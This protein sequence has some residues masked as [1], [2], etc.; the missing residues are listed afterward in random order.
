MRFQSAIDKMQGELLSLDEPG[1]LRG[2][3]RDDIATGS[4][5]A[6]RILGR[7][8]DDLILG[9]P[10]FDDGGNDRLL[11]QNGDDILFGDAG[12][13]RL[14]GGKGRD[15]LSGEEGRDRL[16][17]GAGADQLFDGAG[18]DVMKGGGGRDQFHFSEVSGRGNV[19]RDFQN[20][21]DK[22]VMD[23]EEGVD[24]SDVNIRKQGRDVRITVDGENDQ[25]LLKGVRRNLIDERD[26]IFGDE[27]M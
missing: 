22:I 25:L 26:F 5:G 11:G 24:F 13:D 20:N 14:F 17:G 9:D 6:D 10:R 3:N 1:R 23:F 15:E 8:G 4:T 2:T 18:R 27:L 12:N 21:R 7:G 16:F 19:I